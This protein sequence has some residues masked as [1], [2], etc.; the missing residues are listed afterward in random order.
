MTDISW[1]IYLMGVL[2]NLSIFFQIFLF[3]SIS[4]IFL[5]LIVFCVVSN[6]QSKTEEERLSI[7]ERGFSVMKY[8]S[9]V[10]VLLGF[11]LIFLP[12]ERTVMLIAASEVS[13][14][15]INSDTTKEILNPTVRYLNK[16]LEVTLD[17]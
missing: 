15:I 6:D 5:S 7:A 10:A 17:E 3:I 9:V 4:L 1:L 2:A 16:E 11:I 8:S 12:S 14:I 13:Q